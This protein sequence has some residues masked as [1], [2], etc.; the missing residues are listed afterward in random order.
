MHF[1]SP[2]LLLLLCLNQSPLT[3]APRFIPQ[4]LS[5]MPLPAGSLPRFPN[6]ESTAP[7]VCSA[8]YTSSVIPVI[9]LIYLFFLLLDHDLL[10]V[11]NG[12]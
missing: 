6:S 10:D 7:P 11:R 4:L 8:G 12:F 9:T 5:Q 2:H 3:T 1:V